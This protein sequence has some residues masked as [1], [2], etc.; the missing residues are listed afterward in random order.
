MV[1][2][3]DGVLD[4]LQEVAASPEVWSTILRTSYNGGKG[5]LEIRPRPCRAEHGGVRRA[6]VDLGNEAHTGDSGGRGGAGGE[7]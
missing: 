7:I 2:D 4:G 3:S 6:W 5:R 1:L